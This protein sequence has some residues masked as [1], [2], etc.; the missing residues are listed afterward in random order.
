[1]LFRSLFHGFALWFD[2]TFD[3][4]SSFPSSKDQEE[5]EGGEEEGDG[6]DEA[7]VLA[8]GPGSPDTHWKQM[9]V[10]LDHNGVSVEAGDSLISSQVHLAADK[11]QNSRFYNVSFE[12]QSI[13]SL[14]AD[15][16]DFDQDYDDDDDDDDI[17]DD[18]DE[19]RRKKG[20]RKM[21]LLDLTQD[22]EFD[23]VIGGHGASCECI[24]CSVIRGTLL[25]YAANSPL[26]PSSEQDPQQD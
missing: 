5:R 21:V 13:S 23:S 6:E 17:D 12:I 25:S 7:V 4:G 3:V 10:L 19:G 22:S 18:E 20:R 2:V 11:A 8:T 15:D 16:L 9:V 14:M 26:P 24:K 1:M